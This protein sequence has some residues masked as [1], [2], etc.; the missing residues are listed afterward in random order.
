M[1]TTSYSEA[2]QSNLLYQKTPKVV[3]AIKERQSAV[4]YYPRGARGGYVANN[5]MEF[6]LKSDMCLDLNTVFLEFKL[7][8]T[9]T[10]IA[11]VEIANALDF[12]KEIAVYYNDTELLRTPQ[13]SFWSNQF[14][15]YS[16]NKSFLEGD[17]SIYTGSKSQFIGVDNVGALQNRVFAIPLGMLASFFNSPVLLPVFGNTLRIK[18]TLAPV[19]E[20]ISRVSAVG[21]TYTL[22][23][24]KITADTV[25]LK[26]DYAKELMSQMQSGT[27]RMSYVALETG[28]LNLTASTVNNLKY[29]FNMSNLLSVF[30]ARN[31]VA[32]KVLAGGNANKHLLYNQTADTIRLM[33]NFKIRTGS[34]YLVNPNGIETPVDAYIET[35]KCF[36]DI[37]LSS[38]DGKGV[39]D[40]Q[41]YATAEHVLANLNANPSSTFAIRAN[42]P[43]S[44]I[45][46]NC[47][48]AIL[49]DD[50]NSTAINAGLSSV[51]NGSTNELTIQYTT[52][53]APL[54]TDEMLIALVHRRALV[55]ENGAYT[56]EI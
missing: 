56:V 4:E 32:K 47:E 11:N 53:T 38:I 25:V 55:F 37:G 21:D 23:E 30:L 20:A 35:Q 24:V 42:Y 8:I 40:Y 29:L 6:D 49:S 18:L 2:V 48:K 54:A 52:S 36:G 22:N 46:V 12:I 10:T 16:A 44:I 26:S 28:R 19:V 9:A 17:M 43:A 51:S 39:I 5:V 7:A 45:G 31:E 27:I 1:Q 41:A 15:N 14:L 13:C 34:Q 33:T 3:K 50:D